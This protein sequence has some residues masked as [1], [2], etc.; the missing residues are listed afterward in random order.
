MNV[1]VLPNSKA[2]FRKEQALSQKKFICLN[3][4]VKRKKNHLQFAARGKRL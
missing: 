1:Y 3:D 4:Y 2:A